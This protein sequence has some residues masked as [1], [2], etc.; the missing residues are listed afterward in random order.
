[1][2]KFLHTHSLPPFFS[3]SWNHLPDQGIE[4]LQHCSSLFHL[5]SSQYFSQ[6]VT[7]V[8]SSLGEYFINMTFYFLAWG[9]GWKMQKKIENSDIF[10]SLGMPF[11]KDFWLTTDEHLLS[12]LLYMCCR[13]EASTVYYYRLGFETPW[14]CLFNGK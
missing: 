7:T 10:R 14:A 11:T 13:S 5:F 6:K 8:L 2:D 12:L 9:S 3:P 4:H 1:M